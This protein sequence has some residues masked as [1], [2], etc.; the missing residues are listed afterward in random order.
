MKQILI[1]MKIFTSAYDCTIRSTS[2]ESGRSLEVFSTDGMLISSF[3]LPPAGQEMWISDAQ[4]GISHVDLRE[5]KQKARRWGLSGSKIGC[6]SVNPAHPEKLL[7]SSND[8]TL[9]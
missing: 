4:G 1:P 3:D 9:K 5:D 6:V 8:R 2:F 7:C